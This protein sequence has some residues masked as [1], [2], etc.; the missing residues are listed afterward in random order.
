MTLISILD[1]VRITHET[2]ARRALD[3]ARDLAQHAE[4]WGFRA[5]LQIG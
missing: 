3:N 4:G 5:L 1:F 2:D